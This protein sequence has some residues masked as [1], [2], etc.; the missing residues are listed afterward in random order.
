MLFVSNQD[1]R[2]HISL[3]HRCQWLT[4]NNSFFKLCSFIPSNQDELA[5]HIK[6]HI[7]HDEIIVM[8]RYDLPNRVVTS[9]DGG[10]KKYICPW[11]NCKSAPFSVYGSYSRSD[12]IAHVRIHLQGVIKY[13]PKSRED[14]GS[15]HEDN[16]LFCA[17]E[18]YRD[19]VSNKDGR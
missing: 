1:L 4:L 7:D 15:S 14:V 8:H 11:Q 18:S 13:G 16:L 5:A 12:A 3:I 10:D 9:R 17:H 2:N 6:S 19:G